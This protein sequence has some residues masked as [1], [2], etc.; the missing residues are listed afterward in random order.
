MTKSLSCCFTRFRK[1][2]FLSRSMMQV[3]WWV[4]KRESNIWAVKVSCSGGYSACKV[5]NFMWSFLVFGSNP[6]EPIHLLHLGRARS[7]PS[8]CL[9]SC[10]RSIGKP[11]KDVRPAKTVFY[12]CHRSQLATSR[13]NTCS[14]YTKRFRINRFKML[15]A[16]IFTHTDIYV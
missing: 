13:N 10:W 14:A 16:L 1:R 6:P 2:C 5:F 15:L 11:W 12:L 8:S 4:S 7:A 9:A 3:H